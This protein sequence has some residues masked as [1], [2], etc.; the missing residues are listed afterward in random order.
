MTPEQLADAEAEFAAD[1]AGDVRASEQV[2]ETKMRRAQDIRSAE[3]GS[4]LLGEFNRAVT[5]RQLTE[6]RWIDDLRRFKGKYTPEELELMGN[7]SKHYDRK[8]RSKV[9]AVTAQQSNILFPASK[10]RNF[11]VG[12]TPEPSIDD[13]VR[14]QIGQALTQKL[15]KAPDAD[16]LRAAIKEFVD[17][18]A[19]RMASTI[20]DQ[21]VE[22]R[23]KKV[24][25][26]VMLSGNLYGTGV[27]K[28]PLI[29]RKTRTS[30][31]RKAGKW[32]EKIRRFVVPYVESVPLWRFYP[33]MAAADIEDCQYVWERHVLTGSAIEDLAARK[34]F[35]GAALNEYLLANPEGTSNLNLTYEAE[36]LDM[37]NREAIAVRSNG[38]YELYERWGWLTSEQLRNAGVQGLQ[39]GRQ[40][41]FSNVWIT[42]EGVVVKAIITPLTGMQY[43]YHL[44]YFDKDETSIFGEGL[45]LL[46]AENLEKI[47]A[48]QRALL[49]HA[50]ITAGPMLEVD[51][52]ML[53]RGEDPTDIR[54][55]R[56][57]LK[58]KGQPGQQMV[59]PITL[60]TNGIDELM[61]I[62]QWFDEQADEATNIPRF[63]YAA[64]NP[65][66]GA[67]STMGG[68]SM[69]MEKSNITQ[70][71]LVVNYDEGVTKPFIGGL[72]HWNMKFNPDD[73]IK[74]DYDVQ[75]EGASSLMAKEIRNQQ[76]S[77]FSATLQPEERPFVDFHALITQRSEQMELIDI[78]KSKKQVEAE[79]NSDA[80]KQQQQM[81]DMQQQLAL[82]QMQ[83]AVQK[84]TAEIAKIGADAERLKALAVKD[85][86]EAAFA[87]LQAG[88]AA[89][90]SHAAAM[91]GDE[92][93]RSAGWQDATPQQSFIQPGADVPPEQ[94]PPMP[95][96]VPPEQPQPDQGMPPPAMPEQQ[97]AGQG[98]MAGIETQAM[99]PMP[100]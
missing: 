51:V 45:S 66:N 90:M 94:A 24:A 86:T 39:P 17:A 81:L 34:S 72:Y 28:G 33:D 3:L 44:Y 29:Q 58:D 25:R 64:D 48:A 62:S 93:L 18:A 16:E 92:I 13:A 35:K 15:G 76:L 61:K 63:S 50:A 4:D 10:R 40:R 78:V 70:M 89:A 91:A 79:M 42:R 37:G 9:T 8:V 87:G 88:G 67:A 31:T 21:L 27:L 69:L 77:M 59:R 83:G 11:S 7:R 12:S 19:E 71:D 2:Q 53:A 75:P 65:Q 99:E 96:G 95:Q 80:A 38:R 52:T 60:P 68:L 46:M 14:Q 74:G 57:F 30:Y 47:N 49:D 73:S 5:D 6:Q 20:D 82:A 55:F 26:S 100:A 36:L 1:L 54:P 43:P 98:E 32:V 23:Y 41:W 56:V 84:L 85:R 97:T 22:C